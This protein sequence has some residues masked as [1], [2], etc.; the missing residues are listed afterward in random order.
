M[1]IMVASANIRKLIDWIIR[2]HS[3]GTITS[4]NRA[5][6]GIDTELFAATVALTVSDDPPP[7]Q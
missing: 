6:F 4:K 7:P 2:D 5:S 1:A 3:T